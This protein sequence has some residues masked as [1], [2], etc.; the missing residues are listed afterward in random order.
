[1]WRGTHR[2]E[3]FGVPATGRQITVE[4]MV[5]DRLVPGKMVDSARTEFPLQ[6]RGAWLWVSTCK[7]FIAKSNRET[8]EENRNA[9]T[10][11]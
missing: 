10:D 9:A 6:S 2:A 4:G 3:F 1:M 5:I 8:D 7:W 11:Q